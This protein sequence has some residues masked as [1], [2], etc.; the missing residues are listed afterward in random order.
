MPKLTA[1]VTLYRDAPAIPEM[2]Q[3]LTAVFQQLSVDYEIIFVN[4]RSP[5]N[6]AQVLAELATRDAHVIAIHHTR[7]FGSQNAFT[8]GMRI[9]TGDAVILLDGDLQDPPELIEQF[10][11]KWQEGYEII[12]GVRVKREETLFLQV[13]YKLF[14][15]LFQ[16]LAYIKVPLD[17]G[18]FSLIDRRAVNALNSLPERDR[19]LR[20]MRAWV[21]FKQ[22]GVDY[23]RP[24]NKFRPTTNNLLGNFRWARKAIFSFSIVP[25]EYIIAF[26]GVIVGF[27]FL[28][29]LW[30]IFLRIFFPE[31][32]PSGLTTVIIL[33][34]FLGGIQLLSIGVIG[35]Y[36]GYI[37]EEVKG[38]PHYIIDT[39]NNPPPHVNSDGSFKTPGEKPTI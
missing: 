22:I 33:M 12:Y 9:A 28:G 38:R 6:A 30:Q 34:L 3:R 11:E 26:S 2:H 35:V 10:Y 17:A 21:G 20:G 7:N 1:I 32:S 23:I 5:D 37:F 4:D 39:I 36:I 31:A 25:L 19:F 29:I 24:A 8:S 18:D 27:S 14:Y 15:R 16:R 13:S